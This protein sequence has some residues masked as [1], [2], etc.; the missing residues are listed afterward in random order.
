ME[1]TIS[2]TDKAR[3]EL[4]SL[5]ENEQDFLRLS[6]IPG[7]CS[8]MTYQA[9]ID[10]TRTALD[11]LLYETEGVRVFADRASLPYLQGLAIDYSDDLIQQGFRFSNVNAVR[12][13]G[14]GSS[15]EMGDAV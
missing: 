6:I 9:I 12:S 10:D 14:C 7:G 3:Q 13:C 2:I 1:Q 5:M 8:G 11:Q 15:F 4:S